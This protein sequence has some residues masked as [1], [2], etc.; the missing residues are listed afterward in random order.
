MTLTSNGQPLSPKVTTASRELGASELW[1][2]GGKAP[3][4]WARIK[5]RRDL[6]PNRNLL[7]SIQ[8]HLP[9]KH[10]IQS[11]RLSHTK[12]FQSVISPSTMKFTLPAALA[13]AVSVQA[14]EMAKADK[15]SDMTAK[16]NQAHK[17]YAP[18]YSDPSLQGQFPNG[19][20]PNG[21]FPTNPFPG[22]DPSQ[23]G[24]SQQNPS[25]PDVT[26]LNAQFPDPSQG[27]GFPPQYGLPQGPQP[28]PGPQGGQGGQG[29][30]AAPLGDLAR[31][32]A[33][34]KG[35]FFQKLWDDSQN[36][37]C[38][39]NTVRP[40]GGKGSQ[41]LMACACA[42]KDKLTRSIRN[43]INSCINPQTQYAPFL[44]QAGN[45]MSGFGLQTLCSSWEGN[46]YGRGGRGGRGGQGGQGGQGGYGY[47]GSLGGRPR[48]QNPFPFPQ[49]QQ[50]Q[51]PPP[52]LPGQ[53]Q[54]QPQP[55]IFPFPQPGQ[56]QSQSQPG[57]PGQPGPDGSNPIYYK[58]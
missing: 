3:R 15:A 23:Q 2:G 44:R 47:Q 53:N 55:P 20:L 35:C 24:P 43:T 8:Q 36:V 52:F 31:D 18:Q 13:L 9:L 46:R 4:P 22:Q 16:G 10:L 56:P 40:D 58:S 6:D 25:L 27:L 28:F 54:G 42:N 29:P 12:A 38:G 51:Q 49:Q 39:P 11:Q 30:P 26:A 34:F 7:I 17:A 5:A 33:N 37:D 32:I 50:Q 41:S 45:E 21:P 48:P 19:Q 1:G 57:Q 14:T